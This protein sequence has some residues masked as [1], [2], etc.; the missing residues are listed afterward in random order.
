[1]ARLLGRSVGVLLPVVAVATLPI[2]LLT[3]VFFGVTYAFAVFVVG[4]LLLVPVLGV[5]S[6]EFVDGE[7]DEQHSQEPAEDPLETLRDRYARGEIDDLEFERRVERLIETED[8]PE[9]LE[10]RLDASGAGER[11]DY[12]RESTRD[13]GR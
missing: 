4:W 1:M 13:R 2:G 3:A 12:V 8:G 6:D 11:V 9:G 7:S 10:P 5:L